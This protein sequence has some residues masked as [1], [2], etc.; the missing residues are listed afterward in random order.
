MSAI[1]PLSRRFL[2]V[3]CAGL[4]GVLA[5]ASQPVPPGL[6]AKAPELAGLSPLT[7]RAALLA[8][9]MLLLTSMALLGAL[10]AHRVGLG[11]WLAGTPPRDAPGLGVRGLADAVGAGFLVAAL[12]VAADLLWAPWLGEPWATLQRQ[13]GQATV[14]STLALGVLYGGLAE[15]V[16]MRW[17]LMRAV[18][19]A[20]TRVAGRVARKRQ[21][22]ADERAPRALAWVAIVVAAAAFAAGHLPALAQSIEL[23]PAIV[24]RTLALNVGAGLVYGWLF[25]RRGLEASMASHASTHLGFAL[26]RIAL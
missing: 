11:S 12:L 10:C 19:F 16:M 15:E 4:I 5:L 7:L 21:P 6:L 2:G 1:P 22:D 18:L 23:T 20:L 24:A 26:A 17:G 3:W 14:T 25:W 8:N 9:P 13:A